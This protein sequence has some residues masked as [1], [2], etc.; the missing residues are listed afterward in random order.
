MS[1]GFETRFQNTKYP[2]EYE[3]IINLSGYFE[4]DIYSSAFRRGIK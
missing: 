4:R 1:R 3:Y 2:A